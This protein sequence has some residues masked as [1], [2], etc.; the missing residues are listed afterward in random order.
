MIDSKAIFLSNY[1]RPHSFKDCTDRRHQDRHLCGLLIL[2]DLLQ[3]SN[4]GYSD[5]IG[6]ASYDTIYL[7][8]DIKD[9]NEVATEE[10]ILNLMRCGIYYSEDEDSLYMLV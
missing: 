7:Y 10:D 1:D 2:A 4:N 8:G 6:A 3:R 5:V 9:L